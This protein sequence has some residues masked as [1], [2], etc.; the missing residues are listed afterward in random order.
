MNNYLD[1]SVVEI[2]DLLLQGKIK[3]LD[4][5]EESFKRLNE[6][7]LNAFITIDYEGARKKALELEDMEVFPDVKITMDYILNHFFGVK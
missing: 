7:E 6:N 1:L 5:V 2:H 3:P 4:L